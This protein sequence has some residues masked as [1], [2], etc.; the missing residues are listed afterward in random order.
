MRGHSEIVVTCS[1]GTRCRRCNEIVTCVLR[2]EQ[3]GHV[4]WM[5]VLGLDP[6]VSHT[7]RVC[8]FCRSVWPRWGWS[9]TCVEPWWPT[10]CLTVTR[11]CNC[12][13]RTW[14]WVTYD[15]LNFQPWP[16]SL[17]TPIDMCC[18]TTFKWMAFFL[19][20][21]KNPKRLTVMTHTHTLL[22]TC[23]HTYIHTHKRLF[24]LF[25]VWMCQRA[26]LSCA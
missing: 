25:R 1:I 19:F 15:P 20:Y 11:S 14:G 10:F 4:S 13:W 5:C 18:C 2:T 24:K 17:I 9:V 3:W 26:Q 23:T 16:H 6:G 12:C 7:L 8:V 21:S 22:Y